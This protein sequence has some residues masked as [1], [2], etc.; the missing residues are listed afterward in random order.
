MPTGASGT[1]IDR[2]EIPTL[3]KI[4]ADQL[5]LGDEVVNEIDEDLERAN[6]NLY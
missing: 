4:M 6:K 1:W 3:G 2:S 5:K